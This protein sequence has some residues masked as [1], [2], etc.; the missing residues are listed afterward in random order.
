MNNFIVYM[1]KNIIN[2]K[3]YIGMT[4]QPEKRWKPYSYKRCPAFNSAIQKYGWENFEHIILADGLSKEEAQKMEVEMIKKYNTRNKEYGYNL[5]HGGECNMLGYKF[6]DEQ[7]SR[8]SEARKGQ[9]KGKHFSPSTEFKTGHGFSKEI[10]EKMSAAKKGKPP[11]NK[12]LF[13]YNAGDKNP[14][15]RP[16]VVAKHKGA[17]NNRARAVIQYSLNGDLIKVWSYMSAITEVYGWSVSNIYKCCRHKIKSAYGY[18][19]EYVDMTT[20]GVA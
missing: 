19:W 13:G 9:G 12:G 2:G 11:W 14:M 4:S 6:T 7:R 15:K 16:E 10:L 17:N 18:R 20:K 8:L 5:A 1:H 3:A